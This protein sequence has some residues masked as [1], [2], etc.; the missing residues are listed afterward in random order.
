MELVEVTRPI[1]PRGTQLQ[2]EPLGSRG[3]TVGPRAIPKR[4]SAQRTGSMKPGGVGARGLE[5]QRKTCCSAD[6][7]QAW[8]ATVGEQ[9]R[10]VQVSEESWGWDESVRSNGLR[11]NLC[12]KKNIL[13]SSSVWRNGHTSSFPA[14][15]VPNP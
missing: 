11:G 2:A 12:K 5:L 14:R 3:A 4:E 10:L 13:V 8:G 7:G 9:K 6:N 1:P 15:S